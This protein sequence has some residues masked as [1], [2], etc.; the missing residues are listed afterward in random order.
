MDLIGSNVDL[1]QGNAPPATATIGL[2]K[3]LMGK[4]G[5]REVEMEE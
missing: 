3:D 5:M 2:R 4:N 1:S